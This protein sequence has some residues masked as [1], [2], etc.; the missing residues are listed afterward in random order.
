MRS[1][2]SELPGP[3]SFSAFPEGKGVDITEDILFSKIPEEHKK[4]EEAKEAK[5]HSFFRFLG[6]SGTSKNAGISSIL[7]RFNLDDIDAGDVLLFLIVLFL[8]LEG[9]NWELAIILGALLFFSLRADG[10]LA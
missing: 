6:Q 8:I 5:E 7:K 9:N 1:G 3:Y 4:N 10:D 2:Q